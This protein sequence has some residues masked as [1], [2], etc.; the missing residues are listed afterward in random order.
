MLILGA[1]AA[2]AIPLFFNQT[3]KSKDASAKAQ[4]RA[5]ATA[6]ETCRTESSSDTYAGCDLSRLRV[7]EFTIPSNATVLVANDEGYEIQSAPAADTN[8]LFR[9]LRL[10]GQTTRECTIGSGGDTG[11]CDLGGQEPNPG[12]EGAW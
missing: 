9:I 4:V 2:I 7:I 5:M 12:A 1:L 3:S 11:A 8:N 10:D 6:I